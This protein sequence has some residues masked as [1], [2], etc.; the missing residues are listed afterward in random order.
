MF[1]LFVASSIFSEQPPSKNYAITDVTLIDGNGGEPQEH[2][3]VVIAGDRILSIQKAGSSLPADTEIIDGKGKFLIP[4]LWDMHVHLT[5][6]ADVA[7]P[8]LIAN[9]VTSVCDLG[10]SLESVDWMRNQIAAQ[11]LIGPHIFR[12]GPVADGSKPGVRD[13][14]VIDTPE[15]SRRAITFLKERNVDF[16]K[17][18][19]GPQPE[20][21]F[22]LLAEAKRQNMKVVGHIPLSVDPAK[23]IESGHATVE[24]IVSLFEG[25]VSRA[26]KAGKT[27]EQAIA[28]FTD[29]EAARLAQKMVANKT[30]F[31]PT[32]IAY[33]TRSYQWDIR[34]KGDPREKY[35]SASAKEFWKIFKELP[36]KPEVRAM[37]ARAFD[38]FLEITKIQHRE[39]VRFLVGTDLAAT[40]IYPGFSVHDELELLVKAGLSPTE[41]LGAATRNGAESIGKLKDSGTIEPG[42]FA[43]VVLLDANPIENIGNT[44]KIAV[45]VAAG[46]VF[47]RADLVRILE[48]VAA[49]APSR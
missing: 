39:G 44:K 43:D 26:V 35:V 46:R 19:N 47:H 9:G 40:H 33:W 12:A 7:C 13:R 1:L 21:Y 8:A 4:G 30:W 49:D 31:D 42:K 45:V 27:Q 48:K 37:L 41:A 11:V 28:E 34:E 16:I 3:T 20:P 15:D 5:Y 23:A 10:G 38:R 36:D 18:H 2:K 6:V 14:I 25:P 17:V 22:E 29:A 24:H 32:L